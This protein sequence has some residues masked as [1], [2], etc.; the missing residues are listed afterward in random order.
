MGMPPNVNIDASIIFKWTVNIILVLANSYMVVKLAYFSKISLLL[1]DPNTSRDNSIDLWNPQGHLNHI[2]FVGDPEI[3][4][5]CC[6]PLQRAIEISSL[7]SQILE[8]L[9][10]ELG[11]VIQKCSGNIGCVIMSI[12]TEGVIEQEVS[13]FQICVGSNDFL[14]RPL[15]DVLFDG[16]MVFQNKPER[17]ANACVV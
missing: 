12:G 2:S 17:G 14:K 10:A 16:Q 3:L 4:S 1:A 7:S 8:T 15:C 6:E 9:C 5:I 13:I 11:N